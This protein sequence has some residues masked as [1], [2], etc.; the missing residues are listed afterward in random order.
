[1]LPV[2]VNIVARNLLIRGSTTHALQLR[3]VAAASANDAQRTESETFTVL[4]NTMKGRKLEKIVINVN[5]K[6]G[7][8][9]TLLMNKGISTPYHCA[10]HINKG[11]ADSSA[12]C[13]VRSKD[14]SGK[15]E[16]SSMHLPL[17]DACSIDFISLQNKEFAND[18]NEAYWR[19]CSVLL[20][21]LLA[22]SFTEPVQPAG[23]VAKTY[24]DGYFAYDINSKCLDS[25]NPTSKDFS[26]LA[27][28][29]YDRMI[30]KNLPFETLNV[31]SDEAQQ[32]ALGSRYLREGKSLLCR[33]GDHVEAVDGPV[34]SHAGQ[35]GRFAILKASKQSLG[36]WRF[37]GVSLPKSQSVSSFDWEI[38]TEHSRKV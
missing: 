20:G 13:R 18:V 1:V 15:E 25:W 10:L 30:E 7:G 21:S 36:V 17:S 16:T 6:D 22:T 38:I 14:G 11:L 26:S 32:F 19:S 9:R 8:T 4:G 35:I 28:S 23:V 31:D 37:S 5:M 27:L 24:T 33:I 29:L 34:I 12:L 2:A 3:T